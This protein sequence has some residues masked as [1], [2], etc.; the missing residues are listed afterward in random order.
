MQKIAR[1][2]QSDAI[3]TEKEIRQAGSFFLRFSV[4]VDLKTAPP[5]RLIRWTAIS[6]PNLLPFG[7][8][9]QASFA[10]VR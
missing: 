6:S 5:V 10:E 8:V 7:S 2:R 9:S 4:F 1:G 3:G